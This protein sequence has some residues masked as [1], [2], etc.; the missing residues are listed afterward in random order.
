M[1]SPSTPHSSNYD[2]VETE[3]QVVTRSLM[4]GAKRKRAEQGDRRKAARR[5]TKKQ[6]FQSLLERIDQFSIFKLLLPWYI[7]LED[8]Q[9]C[10]IFP[11]LLEILRFQGWTDFVSQYHLYYPRLVSEFF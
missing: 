5:T 4:T 9:L 8:Q 7:D 11:R 3:E 10:F 1:A 2:D 6:K